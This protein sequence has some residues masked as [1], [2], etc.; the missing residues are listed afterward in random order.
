[1]PYKKGHYYSIPHGEYQ[2]VIILNNNTYVN[3]KQITVKARG[4]NYYKF[5]SDSITEDTGKY[6]K[7]RQFINASINY[8]NE[9]TSAKKSIYKRTV[10]PIYSS[11]SNTIHGHVSESNNMPIMGAN[12][13]AVDNRNRF[14]NGTISDFNGQFSLKLPTN[15]QHIKIAFIGFK[16]QDL[17]I[18]GSAYIDVTM[19]P[20]T[21]VLL[22]CVSIAAP[23]EEVSTTPIS[24]RTKDISSTPLYIVNGNVFI[25]KVSDIKPEQI[26]TV[27]TYST[28]EAIKQYGA[29]GKNGVVVI[30]TIPGTYQVAQFKN[31]KGV[32]FDDDFFE[33]A[34]NAKSIRNNFF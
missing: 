32:S 12:I 16:T 34:A 24:Q 8:Y 30:E 6:L 3:I 29:N 2:A 1:M 4:Y 19:L 14:L 25:G 15:T 21:Q 27:K 17:Y 9:T 26:K 23:R 10:F 22:Q 20:E 5:Q 18:E 11:N 33:Q 7:Y 28:A 31:D 13:I